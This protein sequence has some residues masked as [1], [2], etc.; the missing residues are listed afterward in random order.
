MTAMTFVFL[1]GGLVVLI[2]GAD[3]MVRGASR[4]AAAIGISPLVIGLTVVAFGTSAP[5]LAVSALS[6]TSGQ[7]DLAIGNVVGSNIANILLI[8]GL[9]AAI[10][11]LTVKRQLI[12]FD[13]LIMI[14]SSLLLWFFARDGNISQREGAILFVGILCYTVFLIVQS[15]REHAASEILEEIYVAVTP[16]VRHTLQNIALAIIG[17][18]MLLFGSRMLVD[19]AVTIA[20]ALG[21]GEILIGLTIVAVGTSLPEIATSIVAAMRGE[22]DIAVGNAV[23]SNIFNILSVLGIT[24]II[25]GGGVAVPAVVLSF[26]MPVMIAVALLCLPVFYSNREISRW[27]GVLF[28]LYYA[29][30][31]IYL[32]LS[33]ESS[34]IMGTFQQILWV[35]VPISLIFVVGAGLRERQEPI[36][37]TSGNSTV[38]N[39]L[40]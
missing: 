10:V 33:T 26:D 19:S 17:L 13:L 40:Q 15:R 9:A 22:R 35:A 21:V 12:R 25:T 5:E 31:T 29:A 16:S 37:P 36:E 24:A 6:S 1:I 27:E 30:Y 3:L 11:P 8:L 14:G 28:L 23:G 39:T 2:V 20:T 34:A 4:L 7:D 32:I 18:G 38:T